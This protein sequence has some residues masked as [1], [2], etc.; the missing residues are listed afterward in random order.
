M[1]RCSLAVRLAAQLI[2]STLL[3]TALLLLAAA[4]AGIGF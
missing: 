2:G 3:A 1:L 4:V